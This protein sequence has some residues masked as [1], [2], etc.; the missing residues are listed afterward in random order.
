[1]GNRE[2]LLAALHLF[3]SSDLFSSSLT[4]N[5]VI[6]SFTSTIFTSSSSDTTTLHTA[7]S[8]GL[9]WSYSNP[10][11]LSAAAA[12]SSLSSFGARLNVSLR[13][14]ERK[15]QHSSIHAVLFS[16]TALLTRS[17]RKEGKPTVET[18]VV[19]PAASVIDLL[20]SGFST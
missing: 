6:S 20:T 4:Y 12:P 18:S 3:G 5:I 7:F 1:M 15:Y 13:G 16:L 11:P 9:T 8:I 14:E 19:S 10:S 17:R 2:A